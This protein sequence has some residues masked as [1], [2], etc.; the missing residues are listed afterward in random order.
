M[1]PIEWNSFD[2]VNETIAIP[3]NVLNPHLMA[4]TQI[5]TTTQLTFPLLSNNVVEKGVSYK[6]V[7]KLTAGWTERR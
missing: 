7:E 2:R 5:G 1:R 6:I 3:R 4:L